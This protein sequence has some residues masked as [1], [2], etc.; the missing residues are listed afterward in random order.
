M[1]ERHRP[2]EI[3]GRDIHVGVHGGEIWAAIF[4]V[5]QFDADRWV[6]I[7]FGKHEHRSRVLD[8]IC[9]RSSSSVQG[10]ERLSAE[11]MPFELAVLPPPGARM[12]WRGV[13]FTP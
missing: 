6:L 3:R 2:C 8:R 4:A 1:R 12:K 11:D 9:F 5:G 7:R 10:A 13:D